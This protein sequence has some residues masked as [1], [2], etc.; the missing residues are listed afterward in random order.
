[1]TESAAFE[2][3]DLCRDVL[4]ELHRRSGAVL[5]VDDF[6]A[7]YSN[8][9]RVV[10]LAPAIIKLDLALTRDI[11]KL[12]ARQVAIRHI[13]NM[14][15]ELGA[16]VVAEGVET[17]DELSCVCDLGVDFVQGYLL[18][19]P[20]LPPPAH[21]WP[22]AKKAE[23]ASSRKA[24]PPLPRGARKSLRPPRV[25]KPPPSKAISSPPKRNTPSARVTRPAP[26]PSDTERD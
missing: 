26:P 2:H 20:G 15:K 18:A 17:V 23:P 13:V 7:G 16:R 22:L 25:S 21:A 19:R 5:V 11:D 24:P 10:D 4:A 9:A 6:G 12:K 3:F 8:L 14:C 1:V